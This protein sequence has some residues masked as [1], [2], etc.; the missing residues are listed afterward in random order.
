MIQILCSSKRFGIFHKKWDNI[1]EDKAH[2]FIFGLESNG[3]ANVEIIDGSLHKFKRVRLVFNV[4]DPWRPSQG[5]GGHLGVNP[6]PSI[7]ILL[8]KD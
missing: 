4:H 5:D 6:G 3:I 8:I 1:E 2:K 7:E